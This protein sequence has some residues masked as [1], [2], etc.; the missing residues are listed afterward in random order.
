MQVFRAHARFYEAEFMED[1]MTLGVREPDVLTRVS[2]FVPA[3]VSYIAG[4]MG[5]GLAY[6][7]GGSVYFD[8]RAF[9]EAG[10][11]YGQLC[12]HCVEKADLAAE[13]EANFASAEKRS[14]ADFALWKAA[15]PGEPRWPSPWGEG[16]PG[17]HI[18]C[19]AMCCYQHGNKLDIHGGGVDLKASD[20]AGN[21]CIVVP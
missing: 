18:E 8:V 2:E 14:P 1:M 13:G 9:R 12:P 3:I 17:W 7:A 10:Y 11:R 20:E 19:S 5:R 21:L 16:R 4:I 15:R 6:A